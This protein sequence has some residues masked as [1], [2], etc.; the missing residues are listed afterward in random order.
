M[1]TSTFFALLA[2]LATGAGLVAATG[3]RPECTGTH[4]A[5][6]VT[7]TLTYYCRQRRTDLS[8]F[9]KFFSARRLGRSLSHRPTDTCASISADFGISVSQIESLNPGISC[10]PSPRFLPS[11]ASLHLD[12][13]RRQRPDQ[14]RHGL[15]AMC[16]YFTPSPARVW[17]IVR[18]R[19]RPSARSTSPR[20]PRRAPASR[21]STTSPSRSL[22]S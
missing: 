13:R 12:T 19:L 16:V 11:R 8:E 7:V 21:R 9:K 22:C 10:T 17:L 6:G 2:T 3:P 20:R 15:P 14:L 1:H 18:Q 4:I 5:S